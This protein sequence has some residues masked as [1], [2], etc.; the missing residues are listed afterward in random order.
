MKAMRRL[1][2]SIVRIWSTRIAPA[3]SL[4]FRTTSKIYPLLVGSYRA[5]ERDCSAYYMP[6]ERLQSPGD[7]ALF[8]S[9]R[10][11][12]VDPLRYHRDEGCIVATMP[13]CRVQ[14]PNQQCHVESSYQKFFSKWGKEYRSVSWNVST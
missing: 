12:K 2:Q 9:F 6:L 5:E 10:R 1:L 14:V 3:I 4:P 8:M 13:R 7:D 11:I